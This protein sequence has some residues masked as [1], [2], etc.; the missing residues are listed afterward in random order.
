MRNLIDFV[1]RFH[2]FFLFAILEIISLYMVV[3]FHSYQYSSFFNSANKISGDIYSSINNIKEYVMLKKSN[4]M[5]ASENALLRQ[6]IKMTDSVPGLYHDTTC[7]SEL[8]YIIKYIPAKVINNST[9]RA[10]NFI[11]LNKGKKDGVNAEMGV[12]GQNGVVG[13]ISDV[14]ENFSIAMS[15][16]HKKSN[17]SVRMK[18]ARFIGKLN[19]DG[20]DAQWG[21]IIEVGDTVVTSG[22]SSIFPQN[23]PVGIIT[24]VESTATSNF[25][26]IRVNLFT[27]FYTLDY[28]YIINN[29]LKQEQDSLEARYE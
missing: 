14:T 3:N 17:I 19:W 18:K 10:N 7:L 4:E 13:I 27:N 21:N 1:T 6:K 25:F 9:S 8:E 15:V 26:D 28:V 16:L 24:K 29:N 5:L 23:I 2:A 12:I 20:T 22:F 11:T